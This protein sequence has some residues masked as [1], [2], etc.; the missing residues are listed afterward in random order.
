[1]GHRMNWPFR[2]VVITPMSLIDGAESFAQAIEPD[3]SCTGPHFGIS[4][5]A[6]GEQPATHAALCAPV[7]EGMLAALASA[8]QQVPE[9]MYWRFLRDGGLVA[10]NVTPVTGQY[11]SVGQ[12]FDAVGLRG[13]LAALPCEDCDN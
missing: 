8:A 7:S 3:P 12:S 10:S 9:V 2:L 13:M 11:W 6:T 1:M 4:L 5:S